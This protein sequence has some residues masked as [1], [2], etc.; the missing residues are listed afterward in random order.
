MTQMFKLTLMLVCKDCNATESV[1]HEAKKLE[2]LIS[3]L[4][5]SFK[6]DWD[7]DGPICPNCAG[8]CARLE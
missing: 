3:P 2:Q 7:I 4:S 6:L 8:A 1:S 5:L